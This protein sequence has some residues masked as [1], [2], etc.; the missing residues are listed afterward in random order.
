MFNTSKHYNP[1]NIWLHRFPVSYSIYLTVHWYMNVY[2]YTCTCMFLLTVYFLFVVDG[3]HCHNY[4]SEFKH[5]Q[6]VT[7]KQVRGDLHVYYLLKK[8]ILIDT[9]VCS[10]MTLILICFQMVED[11]PILMIQTL[12]S[13]LFLQVLRIAQELSSLSTS[14]PLEL[15]SSIFVRTVSKFWTS[16]YLFWLY[17]DNKVFIP[18]LFSLSGWWQNNS[19]E[20]FN[21]WVS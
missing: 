5:S 2:I 1:W 21:H 19:N 6:N 14:L 4:A 13:A 18:Q 10:K 20:S 8:L 11:M 12:T 9:N 16:I 3:T 15:S 7:Q 17:S